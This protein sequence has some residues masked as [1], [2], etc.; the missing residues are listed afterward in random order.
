MLI[1]FC[2]QKNFNQLK[3]I[4]LF[5]FT[6]CCLSV[7]GYLWIDN[8]SNQSF[9]Y[10]MFWSR[11]FA[12]HNTQII[13]HPLQG[14]DQYN[15]LKIIKLEP[16]YVRSVIIFPFFSYFLLYL[17]NWINSLAFLV[18]NDIYARDVWKIYTNLNEENCFKKK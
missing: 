6:T 15:T 12:L 11:L 16:H 1:K 9:L 5:I 8:T 18:D 7:A 4:F 10:K 3:Q 13:I 14:V 2:R 17:I